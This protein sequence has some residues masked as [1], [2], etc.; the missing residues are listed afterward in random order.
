MKEANDQ[1][2]QALKLATESDM[3]FQAL[4]ELSLAWLQQQAERWDQAL[5]KA[6]AA[7]D[8]FE[9]MGMRKEADE[10]RKLV[11]ALETRN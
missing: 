2:E 1:Y 10:A 8:H 7:R 11:Q 4:V 3:R 6:V 5:E 9:K